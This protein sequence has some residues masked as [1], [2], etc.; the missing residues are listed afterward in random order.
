ME[1]AR[2]GW[3]GTFWGVSSIDF[4][5]CPLVRGEGIVNPVNRKPFTARGSSGPPPT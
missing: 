4:N 1:A 5:F 2:S 3:T